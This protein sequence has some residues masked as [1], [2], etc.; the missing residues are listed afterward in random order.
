MCLKGYLIGGILGLLVWGILLGM[1]LLAWK[2]LTLNAAVAN[3]AGNQ[4]QIV[5]YLSTRLPNA[6]PTSGIAKDHNK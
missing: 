1:G 3:L 5:N 4:Q 2:I 6:T